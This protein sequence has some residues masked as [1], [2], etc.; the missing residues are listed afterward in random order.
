MAYDVL[1]F[2]E[3]PLAYAPKRLLEE[4]E[5][6]GHRIALVSYK[7]VDF[8]ITKDGI[9]TLWK[10]EPLPQGK[11][12]IFRELNPQAFSYNHRNFLIKWYQEKGARVINAESYLKWPYIDKLTQHFELQKG[13]LPFIETFNFSHRERLKKW[14][15]GKY[16]FIEKYHISSRGRE[17]FKVS[18]EEDIESINKKGYKTRTL[19]VQ[20]FQVGGEDLRI[21]VIGGKVVGAMKRIAKVGSHLTNFSQGGS[22]EVYDINYDPKAK[23]IAE[24]AAKHFNLDY[25]GV[26]LMKGNDGEWKVLEVNRGAQFQGF[27]KA[28]GIN[29]AKALLRVFS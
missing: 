19:L 28:T 25:V 5:S 12:I 23:E 6:T 8:E 9:K 29:I 14:A 10:G 1:V 26:D 11:L 18:S 4:G 24:R 20:P 22:V 3:N 16:P 27:E 15:A 7:Q 2:T 21:I 17:V 13:N